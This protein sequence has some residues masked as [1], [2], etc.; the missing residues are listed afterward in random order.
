VARHEQL[1]LPAHLTAGLVR[2]VAPPSPGSVNIVVT[3][4]ARPIIAALRAAGISW[5]GVART[6]NA[7]G[8]PTP[9]GRG[10]WYGETVNRHAN[11]TAHAAYMR[12]WRAGV[13]R[14]P[15]RP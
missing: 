11:P 13:R 7:Q 10:R 4:G 1:Q 9:S 6:L 15:P 5:H 14:R 3:G 2:A 8:V 12:D